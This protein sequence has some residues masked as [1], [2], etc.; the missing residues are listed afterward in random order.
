MAQAAFE[1]RLQL[2]ADLREL[3]KDEDAVAFGHDLFQHL[4][5]TLQLVGAFRRERAA[6]LK[7]LR[8]MIADLLELHQGGEHQTLALDAL[9]LLELTLDVADRS[10]I[11]TRRRP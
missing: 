11:F 2:T 7:E 1:Q 9:L 6:V 3:G 4:P 8:R 10:R 5:Q